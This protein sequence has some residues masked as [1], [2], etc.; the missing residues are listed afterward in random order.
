[1]ETTQIITFD[2]KPDLISRL[3]EMGVAQEDFIFRKDGIHEIEDQIHEI[4]ADSDIRLSF[5][6]ETCASKLN[7]LT[8][9]YELE[10][11]HLSEIISGERFEGLRVWARTKNWISFRYNWRRCFQKQVDVDFCPRCNADVNRSD[12]ECP[13]C[14]AAIFF[15]SQ[16]AILK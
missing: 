6:R 14:G 4:K 1:M 13:S 2:L 16:G 5:H 12:D 3:L 10:V 8:D 11:L 9:D 7:Q 15:V